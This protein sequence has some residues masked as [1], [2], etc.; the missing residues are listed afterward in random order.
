MVS[1][2]DKHHA[3]DISAEF[4]YPSKCKRVG[5]SYQVQHEGS[6]ASGA[7]AF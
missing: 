4:S 3:L 6:V 2:V 1:P 7:R 5:V